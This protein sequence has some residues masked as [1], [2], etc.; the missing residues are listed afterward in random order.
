M[1]ATET[2]GGKLLFGVAILAAGRSSRMGRPKL[3]LPWGETT[4]LGHLIDQ[5]KGLEA[6]QIAIVRAGDAE[7]IRAELER[8]KFPLE[9]TVVNPEPDRGMFSSVRCSAAWSGWNDGLTHWIIT[10]GDQPHLNDETLRALLKF[11]AKNPGKVCQPLRAGRRRHPVLLPDRPFRALR[12]TA[13]VDLKAFLQSMPADLA[14]WESDD[15]GL[16]LDVDE[17]ADYE[18]ALRLAGLST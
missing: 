8:L 3:L 6:R 10:L 7:D 17:P 9:Q 5:W 4:V 15:A 2:P 18:R 14:G 1:K 16:D 13:A 12:N 11:G